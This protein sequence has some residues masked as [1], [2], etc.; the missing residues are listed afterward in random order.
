MF[1]FGD[2]LVLKEEKRKDFVIGCYEKNGFRGGIT[3]SMFDYVGERKDKAVT[4]V[5]YDGEGFMEIKEDLGDW[6]WDDSWFELKYK[7]RRRR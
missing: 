5:S 4:F 2:K 6:S 1:K 7:K 3:G